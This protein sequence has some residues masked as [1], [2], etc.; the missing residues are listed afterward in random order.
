MKKALAMGAAM[1]LLIVMPGFAPAADADHG[2][3]VGSGFRIGGIYFSIGYFEGRH[4]RP[5]YYYRSRHHLNLPRDHY[6]GDCYVDD[7]YYYHHESCSLAVGYFGRHGVSR[8][9]LFSH[10]APHYDGRYHDGGHYR[11]RSYDHHGGRYG[12]YDDDH[13]RGH[14]RHHDH[15]G[16]HRHHGGYCPYGG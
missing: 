6:H 5:V 15:R 12:Y 4:S 1:S 16:R 11:G 8:H 2:W 14:R 13:H 3:V 9:H 7:G 10:Y